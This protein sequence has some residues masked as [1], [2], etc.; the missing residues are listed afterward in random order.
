[1]KISQDT[2]V[3]CNCPDRKPVAFALRALERDWVKIFG[4]LPVHAEKRASNQIQIECV[5]DGR[6]EGFSIRCNDT[7]GSL[8]IRGSDDLGVVFGIYRFCE[9]CLGVDPYEFWTDWPYA[10]RDVIEISAFAYVS[11]EPRVRFRGWFV[12]DEDCLIG[13]HDEMRISLATWEQIFE[14]LLRAGYNM[15]IPGTA[16]TAHD[17]PVQLADDMGLWIT[18]H[19]A[20]PLG[21]EMF[22]KAY[23]G[24]QPRIPEE[25]ERFKA[26]YSKAIRANRGR[27]VIWM[28]GFRGQGDMPF[29]ENDPRYDSPAKRGALISEMI[30]LQK[31]LVQELSA[32]PQ[33]YAHSLYAESA[34][35]YRQGHL[36]LDDD[37]IRIWADNGF[38]AMRM[39]RVGAD[40]EKNISS[41]PPAQDRTRPN[42]VYYHL[43]FHDLQIASKIVPLVDPELIQAQFQNIF[44]SAPITYLLLNVSN[45]RPHIFNIELVNHLIRF[46][47]AET[48][49]PGDI[50]SEHYETWTARYI[51]RHAAQVGAIIE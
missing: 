8:L 6:E 9:K 38:G 5:P 29:F 25:I 41:L 18:H 40:P 17:P 30:R 3:W 22:A 39:R 45:I 23:P 35:L 34:E 11:P 43:S 44:A 20:E 10:R 47:R 13:W 32:E 51:G 14:T 31:R 1:M 36:T 15:V 28:L 49:T 48:E 42:G 24:V 21:A 19:H 33:H 7:D 27:K 4:Q 2:S 37:I 26:L 50:V 12:N 16:T 46:P